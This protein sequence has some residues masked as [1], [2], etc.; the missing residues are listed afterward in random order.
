MHFVSLINLPDYREVLLGILLIVKTYPVF[1]QVRLRFL[2]GKAELRTVF[3][4]F[5]F[6]EAVYVL[7]A[8]NK[9][10]IKDSPLLSVQ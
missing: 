4:A 9:N 7:G 5:F 1:Q 8:E 2:A 10:K 6:N 3:Q